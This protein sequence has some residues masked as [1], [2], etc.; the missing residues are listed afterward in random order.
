[1]GLAVWSQ[2][3]HIDRQ[4]KNARSIRASRVERQKNAT[5]IASACAPRA[6]TVGIGCDVLTIFPART[7]RLVLLG[8]YFS[9]RSS[10][11]AL[12]GALLSAR[13]FRR[14]PLGSPL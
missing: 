4:L 8:S 2:T 7:S 10:R 6:P 13:S 14:A 1:M 12:L 5:G 3:L 9:A 11:L